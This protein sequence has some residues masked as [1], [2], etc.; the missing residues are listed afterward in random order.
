[1]IIEGLRDC[2]GELR[3]F[4]LTPAH[5]FARAAEIAEEGFSLQADGQL[6]S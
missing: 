5:R 4:V 2:K 3:D 6:L 1:L